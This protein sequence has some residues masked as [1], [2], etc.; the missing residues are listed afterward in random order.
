VA[1][2]VPINNEQSEAYRSSEWANEIQKLHA[3]ALLT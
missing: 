2:I 1:R 3:E